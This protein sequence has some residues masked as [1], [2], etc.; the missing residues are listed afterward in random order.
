M[1]LKCKSKEISN[2]V[3]HGIQCCKFLIKKKSFIYTMHGEKY[4]NLQIRLYSLEGKNRPQV[5]FL[6]TS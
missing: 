5:T 3:L 2:L 1:S 6:P 4:L